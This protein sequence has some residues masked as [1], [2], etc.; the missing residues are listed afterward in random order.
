MKLATNHHGN[1]TK[2]KDASTK[3]END[4]GISRKGS[5]ASPTGDVKSKHGSIAVPELN[6]LEKQ[7]SG[8][9]KIININLF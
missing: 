2:L 5:S 4:S 8:K 7:R 6:I 9:R 1:I 3:L